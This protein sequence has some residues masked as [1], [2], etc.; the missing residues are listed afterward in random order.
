[1]ASEELNWEKIDKKTN[2]LGRMSDMSIGDSKSSN[3]M[4]KVIRKSLLIWVDFLGSHFGIRR[5]KWRV[6]DPH[7]IL[8][9]AKIMLEIWNLLRKCRHIYT[10]IK[11]LLQHLFAKT[12]HFSSLIVYFFPKS[13]MMAVLK[14]F[15]FRYSLTDHASR[16][17]LPDCSK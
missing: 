8:K 15:Q 10:F 12:Q 17:W 7:Y 5:G 6:S 11:Y 9:L 3:I 16:A 13:N 2:L 14:T 4:F 1:M